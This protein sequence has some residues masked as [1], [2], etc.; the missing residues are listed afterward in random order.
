MSQS[1]HTPTQELLALVTGY[2]Q[3]V[4]FRYFAVQS[5][6]SLGLHGFARNES[7]GDVTIVA[8][9]ARPALEHLLVLLRQGP[10]AAEVEEVHTTWREPTEHFSG[11]HVRW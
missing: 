4:G 9:G 6:L 2:V 11:F 1:D 10:P 3:G 5:A 7:N 8:Q